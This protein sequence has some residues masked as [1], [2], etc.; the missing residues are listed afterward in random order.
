MQEIKLWEEVPNEANYA[1]MGVASEMVRGTSLTG[2]TQS[3][4]LWPSKFTPEMVTKEELHEICAPHAWP[5]LESIVSCPNPDTDQQVWDKTMA[6]R[7]Q[8]WLLG[9]L[10]PDGPQIIILSVAGLESCKALRLVA[11][12]TSPDFQ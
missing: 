8:S 7:D 5:N 10:R 2:E 4:G 9:P 1:D 11:L 12:R 3:C 6:E